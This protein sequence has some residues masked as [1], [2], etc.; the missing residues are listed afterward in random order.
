MEYNTKMNKNSQGK[1]FFLIENKILVCLINT[2]YL[3]MFF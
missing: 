3:K 2:C 1:L